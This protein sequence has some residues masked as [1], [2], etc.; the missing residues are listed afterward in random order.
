MQKK[1]EYY[2]SHK[3]EC[4]ERS[5]KYVS[6]HRDQVREYQNNLRRTSVIRTT[7]EAGNKITIR[8]IKRPHVLICEL[9]GKE[10]KKTNYHH[11][12]DLYP[13]DGMWIC[14]WCHCRAEAM[15][16]I[17]F[18]NKYNALKIKIKQERLDF[19]DQLD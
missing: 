2:Q 12:D 5:T 1:K 17:K 4:Y 19:S 16:N 3:K 18:I 13:G 10:M 11:W 9:C 7:D 15:E 6:E 8:C 14:T